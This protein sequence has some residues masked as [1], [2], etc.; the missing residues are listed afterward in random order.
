MT[1]LE[2][3]KEQFIEFLASLTHREI[4][5]LIEQNGKRPKL[6][7]PVVFLDEK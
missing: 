3:Q 1:V 5:E 6:I 4:N 7:T 2:F